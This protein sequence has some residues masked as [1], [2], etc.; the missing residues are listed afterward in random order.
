ML[1]KPFALMCS[2]EMRCGT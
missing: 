2:M 1:S